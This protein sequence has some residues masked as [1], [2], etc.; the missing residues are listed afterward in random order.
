MSWIQTDLLAPQYFP[1][2]YLFECFKKLLIFTPISLQPRLLLPSSRH[3]SH[4]HNNNGIWWMGEK[5]PR[6]NYIPSAFFHGLAAADCYI[7]PV[8]L[9]LCKYVL[10]DMWLGLLES[11]NFIPLDFKL[12]NWQT[13]ECLQEF[14]IL[15]GDIDND[16]S[17]YRFFTRKT[18]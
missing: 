2:R 1:V 12:L 10:K 3:H 8:K 7:C 4:F 15:S 14:L 17:R 13:V 6:K 16:S 18:T 5:L 9:V 11:C